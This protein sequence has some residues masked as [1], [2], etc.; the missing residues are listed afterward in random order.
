M[1]KVCGE[2]AGQNA[3]LEYIE[4]VT[5]PDTPERA[6]EEREIG[7]EPQRADRNEPI[8]DGVVHAVEPLLL[9]V[10]ARVVILVE[11]DGVVLL[12]PAEERALLEALE[13]HARVQET[14]L[15]RRVG[16]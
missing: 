16:K 12:S 6:G 14:R 7:E 8:E 10:H 4:D 5:F 2:K 11:D 9:R 15:G 13:C 1:E 3:P